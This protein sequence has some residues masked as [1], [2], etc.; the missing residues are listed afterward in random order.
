MKLHGSTLIIRFV[1]KNMLYISSIKVILITR[2]HEEKIAELYQNQQFSGSIVLIPSKVVSF[3]RLPKY[4]VSKTAAL[5][6]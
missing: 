6:K 5:L 1:S 3:F 4:A 2:F